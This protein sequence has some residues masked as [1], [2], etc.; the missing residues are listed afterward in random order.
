MQIYDIFSPKA[1]DDI[2]K[3]SL[4]IYIYIYMEFTARIDV[5]FTPVSSI[6]NKPSTVTDERK[7]D[8]ETVITKFVHNT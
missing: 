7:F 6:S 2:R 1:C 5:A 8:A 3:C 4:L